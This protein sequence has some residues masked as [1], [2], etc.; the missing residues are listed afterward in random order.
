MHGNTKLKQIRVGDIAVIYEMDWE[1]GCPV[2]SSNGPIVLQ[3]G[4]KGITAIVKIH[5]PAVAD[6]HTF[7]GNHYGWRFDTKPV[8]ASTGNQPLVPLHRLKCAWQARF[9]STFNPR[10]PGGLRELSPQE[11]QLVAGLVGI[12]PNIDC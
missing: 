10:F 2:Q 8:K 3:G 5:K 4:R 11:W 12:P 7:D 6:P 9:G 1:Y